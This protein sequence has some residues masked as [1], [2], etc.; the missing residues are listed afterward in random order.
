ML[1][2]FPQAF[3][4]TMKDSVNWGTLGPAE[5]YIKHYHSSRINDEKNVL[6]AFTLLQPPN[7]SS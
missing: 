3:Q 5:I 6:V 7:L 2:L 4:R 1:L